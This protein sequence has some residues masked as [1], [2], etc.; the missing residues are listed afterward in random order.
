MAVAEGNGPVN[1]L[2]TALRR[3]LVPIY[4]TLAGLKLVDYKVR[5]LN[6]GDG[7]R[8]MTRVM[9]E[10]ADARAEPWDTVGV[11]TNIIDASFNALFDSIVYMLMRDGVEAQRPRKP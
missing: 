2:D 10:S 6:S 8:A 7:T 5:I 9:I 11:S 3:V 4:P 1:A